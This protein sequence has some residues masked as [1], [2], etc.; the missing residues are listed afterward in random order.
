MRR[1]RIAFSRSA[2]LVLACT[3]MLLLAAP[4]GATT[5]EE[6]AVL[7]PV[8]AMFDGMA[9]H[10]KAA[11]LAAVLPDGNAALLR[12][13]KV[14]QVRLGDFAEHLPTGPEKIEERIRDPQIRID[15]D[16]AVV[17]APYEYLIDGKVHHCGTDVFNLVH[18]DGRWLIAGVADNSRKN[19]PGS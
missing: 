2:V 11:I 8:Q 6:R 19:C 18:Q 13:G 15:N 17:W 5:S 12:D 10:D 7:A 14:H 9:R 16:I 1:S 3:A 4:L